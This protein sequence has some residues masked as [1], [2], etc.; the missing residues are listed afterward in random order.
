MSLKNLELKPIIRIACSCGHDPYTL[1]ERLV[2]S[3]KLLVPK[4]FRTTWLR[5]WYYQPEDLRR[6][7]REAAE[8]M[9]LFE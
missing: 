6:A 2:Y 3:L 4:H 5:H 8:I 9:E 1:R 7:E